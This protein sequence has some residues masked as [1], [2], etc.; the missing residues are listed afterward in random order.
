MYNPDRV[1]AINKN[2]GLPKLLRATLKS[3][4]Y[5]S[6]F[7][8][9]RALRAATIRKEALRLSE[10]CGAKWLAGCTNPRRRNHQ[11]DCSVRNVEQSALGNAGLPRSIS[12]S[13]KGISSSCIPSD[14]SATPWAIPVAVILS[15][16]PVFFDVSPVRISSGTIIT[17]KISKES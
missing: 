3:N 14:P 9:R 13:A 10:R 4:S 11:A 6:R 12:H 5:L 8:Y 2:S 15:F 16:P 1:V 17:V 7:I